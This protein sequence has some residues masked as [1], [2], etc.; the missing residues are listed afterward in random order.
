MLKFS[1]RAST[2]QSTCTHLR[3]WAADEASKSCKTCGFEFGLVIRRHH[4]RHCG[5]VFCHGCTKG[6]KRIGKFGFFSPVRVCQKCEE[7]LTSSENLLS[8]TNCCDLPMV[9]KFVRYNKNDIR[10]LT[11]CF[12]A[13]A[14][15]VRN[16]DCAIARVLLDAKADPN[17][18]IA[19]PNCV[20]LR[21]A[22]CNLTTTFDS[23]KRREF[24]C[25]GC[26][27]KIKLPSFALSDSS[28]MTA[29]HF[30]VSANPK[31]KPQ[32]DGRSTEAQE[33]APAVKPSLR[34]T[35]S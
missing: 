33:C 9:E 15:A 16:G 30:A 24:S 11:D 25:V 5:K 19:V 13:L 3:R 21:C 22:R 6:K 4:C 8:A 18:P 10:H 28:G 35:V 1:E 31:R 23:R 34:C 27:D 7:H 26:S 20:V 29:L 32:P 17:Q 14:I 2:G 12:P